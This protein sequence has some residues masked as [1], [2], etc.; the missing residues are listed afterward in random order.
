[1]R[2]LRLRQTR[3]ATRGE[4]RGHGHHRNNAATCGWDGATPGSYFGRCAPGRARAGVTDERQDMAHLTEDAVG[5]SS[6]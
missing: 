3:M 6:I 4:K 2:R 1:L 5:V